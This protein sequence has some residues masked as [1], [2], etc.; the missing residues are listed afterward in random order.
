LREKR[1][2]KRRREGSRMIAVKRKK[3]MK[4]EMAIKNTMSIMNMELKFLII[5]WI[6]ITE[7]DLIK[8]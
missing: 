2:R 4:K 1:K 8:Q 3:K 6:L 7:E 5:I